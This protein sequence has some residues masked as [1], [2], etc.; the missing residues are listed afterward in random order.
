M[1]EIKSDLN[2]VCILYITFH[3]LLFL[4][5]YLLTGV[6]GHVG[7]HVLHEE[8]K[9]RRRNTAL[10]YYPREDEFYQY[11]PLYVK[12]LE[13]YTKTPWL[14]G[15]CTES[16]IDDEVWGGLFYQAYW[17][18]RKQGR[19][20]KAGKIR[21]ATRNFDTKNCVTLLRR[22]L[23]GTTEIVEKSNRSQFL[24]YSQ[25]NHY[26]CTCLKLL[27]KQRDAGCSVISTDK[28]KTERVCMLMKM[29]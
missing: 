1:Y 8:E 10:T 26:L 22:R 20:L 9:N 24:G 5:I 21:I 16:V 7:H 25:L 19:R 12:H 29:V 23:T 18:K 27:K 14:R 17:D 15:I 13:E 2:F 4:K 11:F 3:I 28:I 6:Y